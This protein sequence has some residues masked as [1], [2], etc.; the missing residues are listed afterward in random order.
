MIP[1]DELTAIRETQNANLPDTATIQRVTRTSDAG[2]GFTLAWATVATV[3]CRVVQPR[4]PV[5]L[6]SAQQETV[7]ADWIVTL[8]HG[9]DAQT[10]DQIVVS[11]HTLTVIGPIT[12]P[13]ITAL[14][15]GCVERT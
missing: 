3:A 5:T 4:Q 1:A 9:T 11:G 14:R 15:L 8:P 6:L 12:G 10:E 2:G 13:W 7:Y